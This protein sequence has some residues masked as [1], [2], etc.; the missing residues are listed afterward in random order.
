MVAAYGMMAG[1]DWHYYPMAVVYIGVFII[2]PG[3]LG[4][5]IAMALARYLD[6]RTFQLLLLTL[7]LLF[8]IG[9]IFYWKPIVVTEEQLEARVLAVLDRLLA[10]TKFAL[11]PYLPSYWL[12]SAL[13]R[14]AE[15]AIE[16]AL[17]FGA[18]LL[19]YAMFFGLVLTTGIGRWLYSALSAAQ[20]R[21]AVLGRWGWWQW[22]Q[23]HKKAMRAGQVGRPLLPR[24][25]DLVPGLSDDLRA[26]IVK[27]I[28]LFWRDT[29]QWAQTV[30]LFGLL[31]V[32]FLNLRH[33]SR[34]LTN[35][36]W[37]TV[38]SFLNLGAC[39][40]N[41]ATLTTRFVYPQ[42]SLEGKRLWIVGL[43]PMGLHRLVQVKFWATTALSW[44]ITAGLVFLSCRML[45]LGTSQTIY[46]LA[47]VTV[48]A[49]TLN[50][51]ATG[52]GVLYPD[53]KEDNPSRIVSG[54]GGTLCL[55]LSFLYIVGSVLIL[56]AGAPW[57]VR[58][59]PQPLGIILA[60][61]LFLLISAGLGYLPMRAGLRHLSCLEI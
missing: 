5:W 32:Y 56:A 10:R 47:A 31:A 59:L 19:S 57:S 13:L 23:R 42:F 45:E 48:M 53:L 28:R 15:G 11:F 33:F 25:M 54:F 21:G 50:G 1:V 9:S 16:A 7:A 24:L 3:A 8:I 20:S 37:I 30:V 51:L 60:W 17:F 18:V 44:M 61:S 40:L 49:F 55:V 58:S 38:V 14:W 46:Q 22:W 34:Q 27:D 26:L 6:R 4:S 35:P 29:S 2:L 39:S 12:A 52:L 43:A 41:L 36:F